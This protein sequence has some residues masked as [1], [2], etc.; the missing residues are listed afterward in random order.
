M[1]TPCLSNQGNLKYSSLFPY[2]TSKKHEVIVKSSVECKYTVTALVTC[3]LKF[4]QISQTKLFRDNQVALHLASNQICH[5]DQTYLSGLSLV[6]KCIYSCNLIC[7]ISTI[8][9][10]QTPKYKL[11]WEQNGFELLLSF[12]T[13]ELYLESTAIKLNNRT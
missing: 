5:E 12:K 10:V 4:T 8:Y 13:I 6:Y 9:M 11:M 1:S 2:W 3:E 7:T